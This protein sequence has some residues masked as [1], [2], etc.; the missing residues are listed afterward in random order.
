MKYGLEEV[1][2]VA[3]TATQAANVPAVSH[4]ERL[5][6]RRPLNVVLKEWLPQLLRVCYVCYNTAPQ[7]TIFFQLGIVPTL[8]RRYSP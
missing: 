2:V 1:A 3:T 8:S 6:A 5:M 7:I 4:S